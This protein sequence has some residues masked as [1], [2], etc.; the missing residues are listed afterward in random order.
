MRFGI[1]LSPITV[2]LG[3]AQPPRHTPSVLEIRNLNAGY[4]GGRAIENLSVEI[5]KGERVGLIGPNGAGKSTLFKSIVG[6]IAPYSGKVFLNGRADHAARRDA[7]YVPQF[8]DVDW[9]F[10]VHVLDVVVMGL[11]RQVGWGRLPGRQHRQQALDALA[12]V[13]LA[14]LAHRAI[15]ELSGGQKRRM[16]IARALAQ[17]AHVLLLDEP[18]TGVDQVAQQQLFETLD[19][20]RRD[21]VTML[22][23][24]HDLN[25]AM[26]HF[27]KLM[28]LNHTLI[29]YG[30][31]LEVFKPD[32]L[33][34]AF[35]GQIA[36]WQGD[37]PMV[38]LTDQHCC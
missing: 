18:F 12:R 22:L 20:L 16:F 17:G 25:L 5:C 31:P 2:D 32:L 9:N 23:A 8:G 24:T 14:D 10:P 28:L 1:A 13:G 4:G 37:Q 15:N 27:D 6:L 38:M 35:G 11:A 7:A 29:A 30:A 34:Q 26:T 21:G 19:D 36:I 3:E 33:A